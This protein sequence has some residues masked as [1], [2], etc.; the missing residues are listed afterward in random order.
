MNPAV[1]SRSETP[2]FIPAGGH[3][4]FAVFT[5]STTDPVGCAVIVLPAGTSPLSTARNRVPVRISR[6]LASHGYH[7]VRVDYHGAGDS[8]G[9]LDVLSLGE[10]FVEDVEGVVRWLESKGIRKI[11]L[12]GSCFGARTALA[13]AAEVEGLA[14]LVLMSMPVADLGVGDRSSVAAALEWSFGTY[15][16]RALRPQTIRGLFDPHHRKI[17]ARYARAKL[18]TLR[19]MGPDGRRSS[20]PR[21]WRDLTSPRLV[22]SMRAVVRKRVPVLILYGADD[23]YLLGFQQAREGELGKV[24]D[25]AGRTIQ[26]ITLPGQVHGFT[27]LPVQ[28]AAIELI[29]DWLVGLVPT[30]G[31]VGAMSSEQRKLVESSRSD[32]QREDP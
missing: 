4:L 16:R 29:I 22:A 27:S 5:R 21:D 8:T 1:T 17:Y 20:G 13:A 15:V 2:I 19:S 28:D 31:Q 24:L 14:G 30:L 18:R 32:S 3:Q 7:A 23:G 9:S 25:G 26:L 10:P 12:V 11:V 6:E